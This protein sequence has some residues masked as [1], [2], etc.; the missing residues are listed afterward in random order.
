MSLPIPREKLLHT[1]M[2]EVHVSLL[3]A[4]AFEEP[5][6]GYAGAALMFTLAFM[7]ASKAHARVEESS[8][9]QAAQRTQV[10]TSLGNRTVRI[11]K[12]HLVNQR[13]PGNRGGFWMVAVQFDP[14]D[15]VVDGFVWGYPLV[16]TNIAI[17]NGDL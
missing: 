1:F 5:G 9:I 7:T 6:L 15:L 12:G 2:A 14:K 8:K 11:S 17:E 4:A 10:S 3:K 16:M 13:S